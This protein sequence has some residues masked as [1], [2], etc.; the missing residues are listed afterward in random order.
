LS[1]VKEWFFEPPHPPGGTGIENSL[2]PS[3]P[4]HPVVSAL[5]ASL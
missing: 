1:G 3:V 5:N 2:R 4:V